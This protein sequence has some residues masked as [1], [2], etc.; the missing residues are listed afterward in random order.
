MRRS[1]GRFSLFYD[2]FTRGN[3]F[4]THKDVSE[5]RSRHVNDNIADVLC[6]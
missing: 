1:D 3:T 5:I 6:R 2:D 4:S